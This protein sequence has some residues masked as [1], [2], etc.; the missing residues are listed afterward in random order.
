MRAGGL[1]CG[2]LYLLVS[3]IRVGLR[4]NRSESYGACVDS[5]FH[6]L[7]TGAVASASLNFVSAVS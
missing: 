1:D 5:Y 3:G 4:K 7:V 2:L 6:I